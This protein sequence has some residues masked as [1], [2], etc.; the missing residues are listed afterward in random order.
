MLPVVTRLVIPVGFECEKLPLLEIGVTAVRELRVTPIVHRVHSFS[1][2]A[3]TFTAPSTTMA[4]P[5]PVGEEGKMLSEAL[6]IVKIQ[7]QQMKR[8]LV[9]TQLPNAFA[10][11]IEV[12]LIGNRSAHGRSEKRKYYAFR[13]TDLFAVAEAIL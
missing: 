9:S 5:A 6:N 1:D 13:A 12:G 3:D 4:L 8:F 11:L 2:N 7:T 10:R